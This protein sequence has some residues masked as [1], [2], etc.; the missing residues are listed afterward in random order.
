MLNVCLDVIF[1][2]LIGPNVYKM[3]QVNPYTQTVLNDDGSDE[4]TDSTA[5]EEAEKEKRRRKEAAAIEGLAS[6]RVPSP[7]PGSARADEDKKGDEKSG[8]GS[9]TTTD[10]AV[11]EKKKLPQFASEYNNNEEWKTGDVIGCGFQPQVGVGMATIFFTRNGSYCGD[12]FNIT[13]A[14]GWFAGIGVQSPET[15]ITINYG[16]TEFKFTDWPVNR[17]PDIH[18]GT[19]NGGLRIDDEDSAMLS[20]ESDEHHVTPAMVMSCVPLLMNDRAIPIHST[21]VCYYEVTVIQPG[22][23]TGVGFATDALNQESYPGWEPDSLGWHSD[24]ACLFY[25]NARSWHDRR[26][27]GQLWAPGDVIGAGYDVVKREI[28]YT[29]NGEMVG[30]AFAEVEPQP[31]RSCVAIKE[32]A[33]VIF[34]HGAAPFKYKGLAAPSL[35][36]PSLEI[37][38]YTASVEF[39]AKDDLH[40]RINEQT[41]NVLSEDPVYRTPPEHSDKVCYYEVKLDCKTIGN[42]FAIGFGLSEHRDTR[43]PGLDADSYGFFASTGDVATNGRTQTYGPKFRKSDIV[44]CG[45]DV[46]KKEIFFTHNGRFIATAFDE[47]KMASYHAVVSLDMVGQAVSFNFGATPF[48][49]KLLRGVQLYPPTVGCGRAHTALRTDA[50]SPL[51][52]VFNGGVPSAVVL[53]SDPI[54]RLPAANHSEKVVYYEVKIERTGTDNQMY[55]GLGTL[56]PG[57]DVGKYK[58]SWAYY[59]KNGSSYSEHRESVKYGPEFAADDIIGCGYDMKNG[60]V[61]FTYNGSYLGIADT[62]VPLADYYPLIGLTS[63]MEEVS[64]NFGLKPFRYTDL[65]NPIRLRNLQLVQPEEIAKTTLNVQAHSATVVSQA[66]NGDV[67]MIHAHMPM[68]TSGKPTS[69]FSERIAYFEARIDILQPSNG[70][71]IGVIQPNTSLTIA[72]ALTDKTSYVI[73]TSGD[74]PKVMDNKEVKRDERVPA[75][76]VIHNNERTSYGV[77]IAKDDVVGCGIDIGRK[78]IFFTR[79]GEYTGIAFSAVSMY[80]LH[81]I[82]SFIGSGQVTVNMGDSPFMYKF[83]VTPA[84]NI[85]KATGMDR[86]VM[87]AISG[88]TTVI[89]CSQ[90]NITAV[91]SATSSSPLLPLTF[92]VA[93]ENPG[94]LDLPDC[95]RRLLAMPVQ[96]TYLFID[97]LLEFWKSFDLNLCGRISIWDQIDDPYV[98][99]LDPERRR[100]FL[101]FILKQGWDL[102]PLLRDDLLY[103]WPFAQQF[104]RS[105]PIGTPHSPVELRITDPFQSGYLPRP[106]DRDKTVARYDETKIKAWMETK[107]AN[108]EL[109]DAMMEAASNWK[110][111]FDNHNQGVQILDN[112]DVAKYSARLRT[113]RYGQPCLYFWDWVNWVVQIEGRRRVALNQI[114]DPRPEWATHYEAAAAQ[115]AHNQPFDLAQCLAYLE[116]RLDSTAEAAYALNEVRR[117]WRSVDTKMIGSV[118]LEVLKT[119]ARTGNFF[120]SSE[121]AQ[122][123]APSSALVLSRLRR[124]IVGRDSRG[125]EQ[126]T[127]WDWID[128]VFAEYKRT[129]DRPDFA[130]AR[131]GTDGGV[132]Q[133]YKRQQSDEWCRMWR[134]ATEKNEF[135]TLWDVFDPE[136]DGCVEV[137]TFAPLADGEPGTMKRLANVS[138]AL[139]EKLLRGIEPPNIV[140]DPDTKKPSV[141][142]WDMLELCSEVRRPWFMP[143]A[144]KISK[145]GRGREAST[146]YSRFCHARAQLELQFL[147]GLCLPEVPRT[148]RDA[149]NNILT[150]TFGVKS[151]ESREKALLATFPWNKLS[152]LRTEV[153]LG[154]PVTLEQMVAMLR[155]IERTMGWTKMTG[156]ARQAIA[157]VMVQV[158]YPLHE[159][160]ALVPHFRLLYGRDVDVKQVMAIIAMASN[161]QIPLDAMPA[162]ARLADIPQHILQFLN[163]YPFTERNS[164]N[165]AFRDK[166]LI[167]RW[168]LEQKY[169]LPDAKTKA[170]EVFESAILVRK[171]DVD[172][173]APGFAFRHLLRLYLTIRIEKKETKATKVTLHAILSLSL[174]LSPSLS[175]SLSLSYSFSVLMFNNL[176]GEQGPA[177]KG[178]KDKPAASR[179][180][181]PRPPTASGKGGKGGTTAA[182]ETSTESKTVTAVTNAATS[183]VTTVV[184][185]AAVPV[186]SAAAS[187]LSALGGLLHQVQS[188]LDS[189]DDPILAVV[190]IRILQLLYNCS[191]GP[192]YFFELFKS[193]EG[194]EAIEEILVFFNRMF[195][196][197]MPDLPIELLRKAVVS[198][199]TS[200]LYLHFHLFH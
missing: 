86:V 9:T 164:E 79:N 117:F 80:E 93:Q 195:G 90:N 15:K 169:N 183:A 151:A 156:E 122:P 113:N 111:T 197:P 44:G 8:T 104:A 24:D 81:P 1:H 123:R 19:C 112:D 98:E 78:Q 74:A 186:V 109:H 120:P 141:L 14:E 143:P 83:D 159:C 53:S 65:P 49:Y 108:R 190:D 147:P 194:T 139:R 165:S 25:Q 12:A 118:P 59:G 34:N 4:K 110:S 100:R 23:A 162:F 176:Y 97:D 50:T 196:I 126:V 193:E 124:A 184:V 157:S 47:V 166:L 72:P 63:S 167:G 16:R 41:G 27:Y 46:G 125:V 192:D 69:M 89:K 137:T 32:G 58:G 152:L 73:H 116:L 99:S 127:F 85:T 175:L 144:Q 170:A 172:P 71:S 146:M 145:V 154:G 140:E 115:G 13:S 5:D 48:E 64:V 30:V 177:S 28:F 40:I 107:I 188:G 76:V 43:A 200:F 136:T 179:P 178:D 138:G 134:P 10:P 153:E 149:H 37:G 56:Q 84:I 128:V 163:L 66:D 18:I 39:D 130:P 68:I 182:A 92:G 198:G 52:M 55:I 160:K 121:K 42:A 29:R 6:S 148:Y 35:I 21:K 155:D 174:S 70:L 60:V 96:L 133:I 173:D 199:Y 33:D 171:G 88:S 31:Y 101:E 17:R 105:P 22:G 189:I 67:L 158:E 20:F 150:N 187:A 106:V 87:P 3:T 51:K 2:M 95:L 7:A 77:S 181:T 54:A 161:R 61:F 132:T 57:Q 103:F 91:A 94:R 36:H 135:F 168:L 82:V 131:R 11:E 180:I 185:T 114:G 62:N 191:Y 75:S 38:R 45:Y 102:K 119:H 26:K 129:V 142:F